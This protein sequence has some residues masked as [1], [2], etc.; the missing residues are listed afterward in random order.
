MTADA[1]LYRYLA[2][3]TGDARKSRM[4]RPRKVVAR[5]DRM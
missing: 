1:A 5:P 2:G 3:A 4:Q